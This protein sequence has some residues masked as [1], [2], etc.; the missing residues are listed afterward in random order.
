MLSTYY[1]KYV[2]ILKYNEQNIQDYSFNNGSTCFFRSSH[3]N[4]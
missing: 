3:G 2:K 4:L 1:L